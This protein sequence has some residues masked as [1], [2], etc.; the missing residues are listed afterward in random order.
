LAR[1]GYYGRNWTNYGLKTS[2]GI[3]FFFLIREN[4]VVVFAG[5]GNMA[6][7]H[8]ILTKRETHVRGC[9]KKNSSG[10]RWENPRK[11]NCRQWIFVGILILVMIEYAKG[12]VNQKKKKKKR[13]ELTQDQIPVLAD[14]SDTT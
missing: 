4:L 13:E 14:N 9:G 7:W 11:K 2:L 6:V 10:T 5:R 3:I 8:V 12:W 1:S